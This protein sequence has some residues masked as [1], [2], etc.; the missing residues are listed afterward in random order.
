MNTS[1]SKQKALCNLITVGSL[2]ALSACAQPVTQTPTATISP[3]APTPVTT[4]SPVTETPNGTTAN[5]NFAELA[6][7]AASQGQF[8]TLTQAVQAAGLNE[9]LTTSG[10]YTVF[11]PTDAAFAALPAGTLDNLLKSENKQQLVRLLAYHVV[12]GQVTSSQITSGQV[13]TVEGTPV[14]I[15]VEDTGKTITVNGARVTQADIPASNG[16]VHIVDKVILP[17]NFPA[18][19]NTTPTPATTPPT[20]PTP[21]LTPR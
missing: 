5:R 11:A 4:T 8:K 2:V 17:P 10:P 3:V 15:K 1:K 9:Q 21:T 12:P 19:F 7:S 14:T 6:Q 16:I 18:S 20:T 13:K